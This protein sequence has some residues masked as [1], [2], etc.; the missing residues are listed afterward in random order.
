M[1]DVRVEEV[2]SERTE[3]VNARRATFWSGCS[4]VERETLEWL[5]A[6]HRAGC[7]DV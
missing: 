4:C 5:A 7:I 2:Y 6:R 3:K 1:A